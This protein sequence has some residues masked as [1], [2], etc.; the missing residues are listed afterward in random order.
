MA[1]RNLRAP[2]LDRDVVE[3]ATPQP[4]AE[5]AHRLP[6]RDIRHHDRVGVAFDDP[7][8]NA[9]GRQ[10][11]RQH[12][13]GE[14]RLLLIE[15]HGQETKSHR[16][17]RLQVEQQRKHRETVLATAQA[18]HHAIPV[19]DH[20]EVVDRPANSTQQFRP[21]P[22]LHSRFLRRRSIHDG[23]L[24]LRTLTSVPHA[25]RS[26]SAPASARIPCLHGSGVVSIIASF[27]MQFTPSTHPG[28]PTPAC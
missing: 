14:I 15:I 6:F 8:G 20:P 11:F 16:R 21:K 18:D 10:V 22:L 13:L 9:G 26:P 28:N 1:K 27:H 2:F 24:H 17:P 19:F 12:V 3:D 5:R 4:G 25:R 23:R 7:E